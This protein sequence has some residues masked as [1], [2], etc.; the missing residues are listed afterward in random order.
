[1][2]LCGRGKR[3][4]AASSGGSWRRTNEK[5]RHSNHTS[6]QNENNKSFLLL[7]CRVVVSLTSRHLLQLL[8][9]LITS[10]WSALCSVPLSL[11]P[12]IHDDVDSPLPL[13]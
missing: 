12:S 11:L 13:H 7:P 9:S 8:L 4:L 6:S 2:L 5:R 10:H 1:M 3:A